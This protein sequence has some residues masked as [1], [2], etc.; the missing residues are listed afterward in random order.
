M[1][2]YLEDALRSLDGNADVMILLSSNTIYGLGETDDPIVS[3]DGVGN[4]R[5]ATWQN[6]MK[7]IGNDFGYFIVSKVDYRLSDSCFKNIQWIITLANS[8]DYKSEQLDYYGNECAI[9]VDWIRH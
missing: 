9:E 7:R 2:L 6:A 4:H 1:T 5:V 8:K 3:Q